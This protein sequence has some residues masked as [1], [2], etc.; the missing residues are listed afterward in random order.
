MAQT[1]PQDPAEEQAQRSA[2]EKGSDCSRFGG[3]PLAAG[4][5]LDAFE[6]NRTLRQFID[7]QERF[8]D[9]FPSHCRPRIRRC[10]EP[11]PHP[12]T[13]GAPARLSPSLRS[14]T[15]TLGGSQ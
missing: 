8:R 6:L 10:I 3:L 11:G 15:D 9:L 14:A 2:A 5:Q 4:E 13:I 12:R 7:S 1:G